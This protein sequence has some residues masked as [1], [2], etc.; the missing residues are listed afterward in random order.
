[1]ATRFELALAG[2]DEA[3]LR[4]VGEEALHE[5]A[6]CEQR[7]S[8]FSPGSLVTHVNANAHDRSVGVDADTFSLLE[9]CA[10]VYRASGGAFDIT[11]G[12]MMRALFHHR[13]AHPDGAPV[14][15]DGVLLDPDHQ[16][17]RFARKGMALDLGAVGKG[18][19][20]DLAAAVL[21]EHGVDNALL[22]G[23]TSTV[24][25]IGREAF[26]VRVGPRQGALHAN[27]RDAALSVSAQHGRQVERGGETV[28]HV[29]DPRGDTGRNE[30][31][32]A[33]VLAPTATLADAWSTATLVSGET[34]PA[35]MA[36]LIETNASKQ[37]RLGAH[38]SS[39]FTSSPPT[40]LSA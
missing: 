4:S 15:M 33:A 1:M 11:V 6:Q 26:S 12:P 20:L 27:L 2:D 40:Q 21:R 24:V 37:S 38:S 35:G 30:R 8:F 5:I 9:T 16:T 29:L 13:G 14:G 39:S 28:G 18:H 10:E 34:P 7:L 23:G 3:S 25:G 22:H 19:A 17:V 32:L 31:A 36:A